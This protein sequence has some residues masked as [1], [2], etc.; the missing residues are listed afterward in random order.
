MSERER[1][2]ISHS[3]SL[4]PFSYTA[5]ADSDGESR[6]SRGGVYVGG[7][8]RGKGSRGR[9]QSQQRGF[10]QQS[11]GFTTH[12]VKQTT[13]RAPRHSGVTDWMRTVGLHRQ[14]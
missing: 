7:E 2:E 11:D 6:C 1:D 13:R 10:K 4:F 5:E 12:T 3:L 8:H 14:T 9:I